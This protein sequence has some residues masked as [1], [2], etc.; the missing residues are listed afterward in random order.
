MTSKV[1]EKWLK[2][3]ISAPAELIDALSNFLEETGAQ[4]VFSESL[5]PPGANDFP[6]P[7]GVEIINAFSRLTSAV[8]SG[9]IPSESI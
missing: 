8:K 1:P 9:F 7:A 6:E 4:G 3:G 5:L 2:I